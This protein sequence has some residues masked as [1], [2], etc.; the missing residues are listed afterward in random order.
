MPAGRCQI[1]VAARARSIGA[2]ISLQMRIDRASTIRLIHDL[3]ASIDMR[4]TLTPERRRPDDGG[5]A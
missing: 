4:A 3:A 1:D 2:E 5:A